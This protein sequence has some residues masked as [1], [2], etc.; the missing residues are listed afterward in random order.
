[1]HTHRCFLRLS[2]A[3]LA[4]APQV[5]A[6]T[7]QAEPPPEATFTARPTATQ[8]GPAARTLNASA[9]A[10]LAQQHR[11]R[12]QWQAALALYREGK[13]RYPDD[14]HF[15]AREIMT[16]ADAGEIDQALAAAE[17][18]LEKQPRST[19]LNLAQ[20]YAFQRAAKPYSA[21]LPLDRAMALEPRID[22]V[23]RA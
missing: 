18:A 16:L 6:F 11:D 17:T 12:G 3:C 14:P 22:Y 20:A 2:L 9:L 7:A 8:T 21:L 13:H 4:L 5:W 1:M 23:K 19:D 15:A 10:R